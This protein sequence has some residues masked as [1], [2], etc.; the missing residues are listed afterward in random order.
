MGLFDLLWIFFLI[1]ALQPILQQKL[2]EMQCLRLLARLEPQRGSRAIAS[3]HRR[4]TMSWLGVPLMRYIDINDSEAVLRGH[5][6]HRG[7]PPHRPDPAHPGWTGA[8]GRHVC[9][10]G[11]DA[12]CPVRQWHPDPRLSDHRAA[13]RGAGTAGQHLHAEGGLRVHAALSPAD[14]HASLDRICSGAL[15]GA[16]GSRSRLLGGSVAGRG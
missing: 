12:G 5:P 14:A 15:W 3:V 1:S 13:R 16:P 8:S 6:A 11:P 10:E 7:K 9:H 2:L 4:E